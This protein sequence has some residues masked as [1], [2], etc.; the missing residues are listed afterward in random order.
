MINLRPFPVVRV[1][2]PFA[3]GSL[4]GYMGFFEAGPVPLL[5]LSAVLGMAVVLFFSFSREGVGVFQCGFCLTVLLLLF[6]TGVGIGRMDRPR[7]PGIPSGAFVM[8]RGSIEDDPVIRNGKMVFGVKFRMAF[9]RDSI[10]LVSSMLKAYMPL[11]PGIPRP[12]A[13]ETWLL[14]GSLL[15]VQNSGNPGEVDYASI[16]KRKNCWYNFYCDTTK[17]N[18]EVWMPEPGIPRQA[19]LRVILSKHWEGAPETIALLRAVCL[20]DR[21]GLSAEL[22]HSYSMAGGMHVLAVSGLHIGLIWWVLNRLLSFIV[23]RRKGDV[24]RAVLIVL[25][26]WVFAYVTGFSSSVSR[27]VAMFSFYSLSRIIKHRSHPVNAILVSMFILILFH[28]GRLLDLG[29]QLSYAAILSIVTLN[30]VFMR[31]WRPGNF[32][33]RW[34]WEATCLSFAAQIGTLPLVLLYFHQLPV[35]GLLSNLVLVPLLSCIITIF[36]VSAPMALSGFGAGIASYLLMMTARIMNFFVEAIASLPGAVLGGLQ[37]DRFSAFIL[38]ILIFLLIEFLTRKHRAALYAA[39]L[40][41]CIMVVW[42]SEIKRSM[43][44]TSE[45]RISHF[46]GGSLIT[47]KVGPKVDHYVLTD[48][49]SAVSY[50]DRYLSIAW[51]MRSYEVSVIRIG[52]A[53]SPATMPGGISCAIEITEGVFLLGN[54]ET[55]AMV[56]S[57]L[58]QG[59]CPLIPTGLEPCFVLLSDEPSLFHSIFPSNY[60]LLVADGSNRKWYAEKLQERSLNFYNTTRQGAFVLYN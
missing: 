53:G 24:F 13:G 20:G 49:P 6:I 52:E 43:L 55:C 16:L 58:Y 15:P 34:I 37:L 35:Y 14:S 12:E 2:I 40:L 38:M 29:F 51:G 27:S 42:T 57:G 31:I 21:S 50:M 17:L 26:L 56:I 11:S 10:Y 46:R 23:F 19:E 7:D 39:V 9:T 33:M 28:P 3:I 18:K 4:L 5:L 41:G 25:I 60:P 30:P 44:F 1:L 48:E 32:L 45:I 54:N 22:R 47:F 36:V 8:L 59:D